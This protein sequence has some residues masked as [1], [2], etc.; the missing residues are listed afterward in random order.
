[1][2]DHSKLTPDQL[3]STMDRV[4]GAMGAAGRGCPAYVI[5]T[6]YM[7]GTPIRQ[8]YLETAI[9]WINDGDIEGY[10]AAHQHDPNA[11]QLWLYFQNLIAWVTATFTNKRKEMRSVQWGPLH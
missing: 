5:G 2:T 6:D 1:M 7:S 3:D 4:D 11:T 9:K 10:M 8:D